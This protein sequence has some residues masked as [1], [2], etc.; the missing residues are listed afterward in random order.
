MQA[1]VG[2]FTLAIQSNP[3]RLDILE[4]SEPLVSANA[5]G[6][7]K[8]EHMRVKKGYVEKRSIVAY[9]NNGRIPFYIAVFDEAM[10]MFFF[11]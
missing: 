5:A 4:G 1:R 2:K 7:L 9:W 10:L 6:L 8:F 3:F 11:V